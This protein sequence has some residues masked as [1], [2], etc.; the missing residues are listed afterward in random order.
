MRDEESGGVRGLRAWAAEATTRGAELIRRVG[1]EPVTAEEF[2]ATAAELRQLRLLLDHDRALL[3]TVTLSLGALLA[4]RHATGQG[5]PADREEARRLLEEVRDPATPAGEAVPAEGRRWAALYLLTLNE[6][7]VP[8]SG[9]GSAP[10]FWSVFD[11]SLGARHGDPAAEAAKVASLAAELEGLPLP[12]EAR[13]Q[14]RQIQ[15]VLSYVSRA[16]FSDPGTLMSMLPADF[17]FTEQLRML[18][19][20]M[21]SVPDTPDTPATPAT[22]A[23]PDTP[24]TPA[25]SNTEDSGPRQEPRA[26]T[27]AEAEGDDTVT[28]AWLAALLGTTEA[29][30]DGDPEA[31][32]RLLQRLAG[33]LDR[34]PDGHDRA[35]EIRQ[36][37]GLVLQTGEPLGGSRIDGAVAETHRESVG[38]HYAR[39]AEA[40][41]AAAQLTVPLRAMNLLVALRA[42][43][44]AEDERELLRLVGELAELERTTPED[45]AFRS[46]VLLAHGNALATLGHRTGNTENM[47]RGLARQQEALTAS[48]VRELGLPESLL[49]SVQEAL[50]AS[51]AVVGGTP[52][53]MPAPTPLPANASTDTRYLAGLS[54]TLRHS[55]TRDPADLDFA[56]GELEQ[57]RAQVRKGRSPQ[58]A[59]DALWQLAENYRTRSGRT[60]DASDRA[61][62]TNAA[63]EALQ[64]LAGDV[65]LQTGPDHG[66]LAARSGADRGVRAAIWAAAEGRVEDAVAALELGRALV[67]QAAA[68]SRAVPELLQARGH[69]ELARAWR[70]AEAGAPGT[71]DGLPRELP[72]SLRRRALQALGHRDPDGALFRTPTV[73]EL[74]AGVAAG[75]ADALVYLLAGQGDTPGMAIVVGPD[76][77]TGV[78]ALPLLSGE[79]SGPLERY[80]DAAGA[81]QRQPRDAGVA[82]AWEQALA[83]L[84]DWATGAVIAPVMTGIAER[85]AADDGRRKDRPGPP[86]L[87]LVPC[88]RL[89][90]VPWHAARLPSEAPHDYV[91]EAMVI[92]YAASGRQFLDTVRRA[93]RVP[94]A[95]AVLVAD[96]TMTLTHAELEVTALRQGPYPEARLYGDFFEPPVEPVGP[97]TP[98]DLLDELTGG[99]SLLHLAC[100]GSAGVSPTES[101]LQ[102]AS[103]DVSSAGTDPGLLTVSRLLARPAG[104]RTGTD[105]PL[106]VLSACETDLTHRDHDEALTLTT[107]FVARGARDVVGSRWATADSAAALMMAVFHHYLTVEGRSPVDALRAAQA[108]MLNPRRENPGSLD[109]RLLDELRKGPTLDHP[110]AWAAFIHQ[111]HPGPAT[112]GRR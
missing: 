57:V 97:G 58:L 77:G 78:R 28:G 85:L 73:G 80:L 3:G 72:S 65:V 68:T 66:L 103:P 87:V 51:R 84:C 22:P 76:T 100:H 62:A 48:S 53:L 106:V 40:D 8:G 5:T 81:R 64:A 55:V 2:D 96:P 111:G 20:L 36:L 94:G 10:D 86:R 34:L 26:R 23:T 91:C 4:M 19:N 17:P 39:L 9:P 54:A 52:D 37:I 108:W 107:A 69:C 104:E 21:P 16:D 70:D 79:H 60:G 74:K 105:G 43:E 18:L 47:V 88:G 67:L 38:E 98:D 42:A 15:D 61:A 35:G 45:H 25:T 7:A 24:A 12:P 41:P 49:T 89:G 14:V 11:Q 32:S 109:G 99:A 27:G 46:L 63:L 112:P 56:I 30:R 1:K 71:A 110:A 44:D 90:I 31:L 101:S 95:A 83:E 92:S 6:L 75:D 33:D 50:Q 82:Q 13:D 29:M 93:P 59:G 102:L